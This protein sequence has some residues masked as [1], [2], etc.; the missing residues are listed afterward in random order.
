MVRAGL[1]ERA[2][3]GRFSLLRILVVLAAV[4][5]FVQIVSFAISDQVAGGRP[6]LALRVDGRNWKALMAGA[7]MALKE[8]KFE[9]AVLDAQ[10]ALRADPLAAGALRV[11]GIVEEKHGASDRT[12]RLIRAAADVS[13]R[14]VIPQAWL[15]GR[16][17]QSGDLPQAMSRLD[18]IFRTANSTVSAKLVSLLLPLLSNDDAT[19]E[20]AK[21][22]ERRP[23]WRSNF[24]TQVSQEGQDLRAVSALYSALGESSA[25]PGADELRPFLDRLIRTGQVED[26]YVVW[27]QSLPPERLS[28][29]GY[30]YNAG[31]EYP[32]SHLPFD[33][34]FGRVDA[35]MVELSSEINPPV[36]K[37]GFVGGRV[38]QPLVSHLIA[39]PPGTYRFAG[40][41]QSYSLAN[42][43]GLRWR[44]SCLK[45]PDGSLAETPPLLGDTPWRTFTVS[46]DVNLDCPVQ[47]LQLELRARVALEQEVSGEASFADLSIAKP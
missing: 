10:L 15:L 38:S 31:F 19:R 17:L 8:E 24:L 14:D 1:F 26:A 40:R 37:V 2:G 6:E 41:E 3:T 18:L 7:E 5:A 43:R 44:I 30:L 21:L 29:L 27:T 34:V 20:V 46:F 39:L 35:A 9:E 42:E 32:V 11:L 16:N 47:N 23:P 25:P 4:A 22:L 45:E 28:T 33:W 36:L 13:R 12:E